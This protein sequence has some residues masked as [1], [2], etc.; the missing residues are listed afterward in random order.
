MSALPLPILSHTLT[1]YSAKFLTLRISLFFTGVQVG[2]TP[3]RYINGAN[4]GLDAVIAIVT[5]FR[6]RPTR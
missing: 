5:L 6:Y 4:I 3:R 2:R 1:E